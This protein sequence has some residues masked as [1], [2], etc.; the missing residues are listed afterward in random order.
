MQ[1][2]VDAGLLKIGFAKA[3]V[4]GMI[5]VWN[6]VLFRFFIF[7]KRPDQMELESLIVQ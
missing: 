7:S 2:I 3:V 4:T 6:F 5:A 1:L